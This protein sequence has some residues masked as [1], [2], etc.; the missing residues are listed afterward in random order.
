[1]RKLFYHPSGTLLPDGRVIC[2]ECGAELT[3]GMAPVP[4]T[5]PTSAQSVLDRFR[6]E[7]SVWNCQASLVAFREE[8][9]RR[10]HYQI[11]APPEVREKL[12]SLAVRSVEEAGGAINFSGLYPLNRE[13]EDLLESGISSGEIKL[14]P[15][16]V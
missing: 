10:V 12:R 1:M 5:T 15:V 7:I 16:R 9:G 2:T 6:F 13:L 14:T 3:D 8:K 4:C 11:E